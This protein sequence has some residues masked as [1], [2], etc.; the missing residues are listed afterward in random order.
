MSSLRYIMYLRK[1]SESEERQELSI[2]AQARELSA[3]AAKRNLRLVGAPRE[4][5]MS[6][7]EPGRP[8]FGAVVAAIEAGKADGILCWKLDRL[9]RNPVDGGHIM[10]ALG[11]R[12]IKEIVTP[13]RVYSGTGDDKL[14]MSIIFGMATKYS[15]DLSDN[16]RRGNR[17]ALLSGRWPG[18]P[19]IGYRRDRDSMT[20]VPDPERFSLVQRLWQ[21][22][23]GGTRPLAALQIAREEMSLTTQH[24]GRKGG[25]L[26]SKAE[27]YRILRSPFY[28]GIMVRKGESYPGTHPS[29]VTLDEYERVQAI[30]DGRVH[31]LARPQHRFFAYGGLMRCGRCSAAI[32]GRHTIN[33]YGKDYTYYHCCRKERRYLFC[34]ERA[35]QER[36]VEAQVRDFFSQML[37]PENWIAALMERLA[38]T[39]SADHT[40]D[41]T[42]RE[43]LETRLIDLDRALAR[44]RDLLT[45]GVITEEEYLHD[46]ALHVTERQRLTE[47]LDPGHAP[48]LVE[49]YE[50]AIS[51]LRK[52]K[53]LFD[54]GTAEEKRDIVTSLTCNLRL[55][56]RKVV[57]Q[58]KKTVSN[59]GSWATCQSLSAW[60]DQVETISSSSSTSD[61]TAF[62]S[63]A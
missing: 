4:E 2:P 36:D 11:K 22:V 15:D 42:G 16:V 13:D 8:L 10:Y 57:I 46:R 17:E 53:K 1:S 44:E 37:P 39:E 3:L 59:V 40:L 50:H 52:A 43:R 14:L 24:W 5:S 21:L 9:A 26:L 20:L 25:H 56:D 61:N 45:R 7:K 51:L 12:V 63:S 34:P 47:S 41:A 62:Q 32:V 49:P 6:A 38:R 54:D 30:L 18:K 19:K 48:Q 31:P 35:V 58:A 27:L 23:L 33:R 28:A 29:M 55:A 60:L